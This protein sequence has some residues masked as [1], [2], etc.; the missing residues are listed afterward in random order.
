MSMIKSNL[1]KSLYL[2]LITAG[3]KSNASVKLIVIVLA[4]ICLFVSV[5]FGF[6]LNQKLHCKFP[7]KKSNIYPGKQ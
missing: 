1:I 7:Q 4:Q 6:S 5:N 2:V 3:N